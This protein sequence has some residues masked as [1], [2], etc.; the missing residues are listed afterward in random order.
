LRSDA[1]TADVPMVALT[2]LAM[3]GD[4]ERCLEAGA[5]AYLSKPVRLAEVLELVKRL[6]ARTATR[7]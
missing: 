1:S 5:E 4:R 7:A 2:A 6:A 3:P